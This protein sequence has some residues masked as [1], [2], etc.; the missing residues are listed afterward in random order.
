MDIDRP[1]EAEENE[2]HREL[3]DKVMR[4]MPDEEILYELSELF[5]VFGD[6]TRIR[7]LYALYEEEI[8]VCDLAEVLNLSQSAVSHQLKNLKNARLVKARRE[9]KQIF[10][11][12]SDTHVATIIAVGREHIEEE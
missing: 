8:S 6:S 9:G 12:L 7:I 2:V 4:D 10:Y 5:K 11:S 1:E 3:V